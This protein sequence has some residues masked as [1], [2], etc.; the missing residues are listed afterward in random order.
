MHLM[1]YAILYWIRQL[2]W[3]GGMSWSNYR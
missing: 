1:L 2:F 3:R